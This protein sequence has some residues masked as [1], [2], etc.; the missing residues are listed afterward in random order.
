MQKSPFA[1][2]QDIIKNSYKFT[3]TC[4]GSRFHSNWH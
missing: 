3:W 4:T 1:D 2:T